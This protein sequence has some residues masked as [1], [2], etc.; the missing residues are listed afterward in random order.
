MNPAGVSFKQ[1]GEGHHCVAKQPT[2]LKCFKN[3]GPG[4]FR[5]HTV[6][7]LQLLLRE[8]PEICVCSHTCRKTGK[9]HGN[10]QFLYSSSNKVELDFSFHSQIYNFFQL[11]DVG[12]GKK[13][14]CSTLPQNFVI[15]SPETT[16][17]VP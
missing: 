11:L 9:L 14:E 4:M 6:S 13:K 10:Y 16:T 7:E 2:W 8:V 1:R 17:I 5:R 12:V 3:L 15:S